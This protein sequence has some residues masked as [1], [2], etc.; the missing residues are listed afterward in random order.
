MKLMKILLVDDS[1]VSLMRARSILINSDVDCEEILTSASGQEALDL[2]EVETV[3]LVLL[4]IVMPGLDGFDVLKRIKAQPRHRDVQVLMLTGRKDQESI[5]E[6]FALGAA[7]YITKPIE[8]IEF[9]ARVRAAVRTRR[10][11]LARQQVEKA[12]RTA[13][14]HLQAIYNSVHDSISIHELD[15]TII[16][17]NDRMLVMFGVSREQVSTLSIKDDLSNP[18]I[19]SDISPDQL[20]NHWEKAVAGEN[21]L[22]E[23]KVRRPGDGTVFDAEIFLRKLTLGKKEMIL[24]AIRD[25]TARKQMEM[26]LRYLSMHDSLTG[27]YNRA[28]FEEE[29]RRLD[30]GREDPVSL[31]VCDIDGLKPV[32]DTLGHGAGDTLLKTAAHVIRDA[33]R[34]GDAVARVGGDEFAVLLPRTNSATAAKMV[35]RLGER[36]AKYNTSRPEIPLSISTGYATREGVRITLNELFRQADDNMYR[37]K[38]CRKERT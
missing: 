6:S 32:N 8:E 2:M 16:D 9:L 37:E 33:F 12:L 21:L 20:S 5:M 30:A 27:L 25:I 10:E 28:Y 26:Q 35:R 1:K 24:A 11:I 15:G 31:V 23:W 22:F 7:D 34:D 38:R 4:D 18:D 3:D 19:S 17:V 36:V 14:D 29:M 13:K